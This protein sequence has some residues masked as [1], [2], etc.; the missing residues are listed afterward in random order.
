MWCSSDLSVRPAFLLETGLLLSG[1]WG[2]FALTY[3]VVFL[4][5]LH[6]SAKCLT[7]SFHL[8]TAAIAFGWIVHQGST[9]SAQPPQRTCRVAKAVS[10]SK[11]EWR[12]TPLWRGF[13]LFP[14]CVGWPTPSTS[15][16]VFQEV[17][18]TISPRFQ[19]VCGVLHLVVW[20]LFS[21]P[22]Y[23]L[24]HIS[25]LKMLAGLP[26]NCT[27]SATSDVFVFHLLCVHCTNICCY[28]RR[29]TR[30]APALVL[31]VTQREHNQCGRL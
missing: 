4:W 15:W 14:Q 2:C 19:K 1:C 29:V 20:H 8:L 23:H 18:A 17:R 3:F 25:R 12:D 6:F 11:R 31:S 27:T 22:L 21:N 13:M 7:K 16:S 9:W 5:A 30:G 26:P 24:H 28:P 10:F